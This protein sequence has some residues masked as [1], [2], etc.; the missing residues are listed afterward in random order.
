MSQ[1]VAIVLA[2][3]RGSRMSSDIPKQYMTVNGRP[4]LFYSLDIFEKN[5]NIDSIVLVAPAN[6]IEYCWNE[7]VKKYNF[8]KVTAVI[9]GGSERYL[10]VY[11]ALQIIADNGYVFIHDA[12]RPCITGH[13]I[14]K[15]YEDVKEHKAVVA[16][17]PAK[18]T[19]KIAENGYV[20]FT[21]QRENVWIIQTPQAFET[22]GIKRAYEQMMLQND[23]TVTDDAMVMERYGNEK[24][25]LSQ[26]SYSNIKITTDEDIT[27]V[28]N[29]LKKV[30]TSE[31]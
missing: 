30:L 20:K 27:L 8:T 15:L 11:N 28:E 2:A 6:D 4:V 1:N 19:I 12:A 18:D 26:A 5:K 10:S 3:G 24:I 21:P 29:F 25:Y 31:L 14:D 13:I 16:A 9:P 17:V 23:N 22:A 7:I